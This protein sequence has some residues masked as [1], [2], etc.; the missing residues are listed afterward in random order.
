MIVDVISLHRVDDAVISMSERSEKIWDIWHT[1]L[2]ERVKVRVR[3]R[4]CRECKKKAE[5]G[6]EV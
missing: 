6:V 2:N 5:R 3:R 1:R 4:Y